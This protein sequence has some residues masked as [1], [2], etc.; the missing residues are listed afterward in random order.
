MAGGNSSG[1]RPNTKPSGR[2][3]AEPGLLQ[4]T[5]SSVVKLKPSAYELPQELPL[6]HAV[7]EGFA[8]IDK[9]HRD[10]VIELAAQLGIAVHVNFAPGE[11]TLA[12][13]LGKALLYHFTQMASFARID[14]DVACLGHAGR[15]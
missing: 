4:V 2:P 3:L 10:F 12:R 8:S 9:D 14:Y 15:F 6:V 5:A 7:L 13:E 11:T 1:M